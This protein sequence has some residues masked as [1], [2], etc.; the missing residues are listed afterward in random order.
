[1]LREVK[2]LGAIGKHRR[3]RFA[4]VELALVDL[5]DV[6]DDVC[7]DPAGGFENLGQTAKQLVVRDCFQ[8]R[9]ST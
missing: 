5:G 9:L 2:G 6:G 3:C 8:S 4:G 1:M 7:L